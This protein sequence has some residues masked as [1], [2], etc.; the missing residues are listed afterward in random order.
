ML[1]KTKTINYVFLLV[2]LL[3]FNSTVRAGDSVYNIVEDF[4]AV[5]NGIADD[6][7]AIQNAIDA[8]FNDGGGTVLV[9]RGKYRISSTLELKD[10]VRLK[11]IGVGRI[12]AT[13]SGIT[14]SVIFV[15]GDICG[16]NAS[17][18][19]CGVDGMR[20]LGDHGSLSG[21]IDYNGVTPP[22]A[23]L[24]VKS[25]RFVGGHI[26]VENSRGTGFYFY[27]GTASSF[28]HITAVTNRSH[29][30]Y[31]DGSVINPNNNNAS[32]FGLLDSRVN[33]GDGI[34]VNNC[35][36]HS[37]DQVVVQANSGEGLEI[38]SD[39]H[40]ILNVY[41]EANGGIG[42]LL[43]ADAEFNAI[44]HII[45]SDNVVD[46]SNGSNSSLPFASAPTALMWVPGRTMLRI[47]KG[48][49]EGVSV[50]TM[51]DATASS[52]LTTRGLSSGKCR[53]SRADASSAWS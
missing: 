29:G 35:S 49:R 42:L 9:P 40:S 34:H 11:G 7:T 48:C 38:N 28:T 1:R 53:T 23:L 20:L 3:A 17:G 27:E 4:N 15:V 25:N 52:R 21:N 50:H 8:A 19:R 10:H 43:G 44:H 46:N 51:S 37:F 45:D 2:A 41:T 6:S 47:T 5:G 32:W 12:D 31:I 39:W 26:G 33:D 36:N 22:T 18:D 16:I 30:I 14:G 13:D 24:F